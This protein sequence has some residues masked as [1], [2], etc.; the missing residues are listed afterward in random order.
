MYTPNN[1][2]ICESVGRQQVGYACLG[3]TMERAQAAAHH[4]SI[5]REQPLSRSLAQAVLE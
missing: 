2:G 3:A 4:S 1:M 5:I